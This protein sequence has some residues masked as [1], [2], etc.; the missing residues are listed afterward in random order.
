MTTEAEN[1]ARRQ[2]QELRM[3]AELQAKYGKSAT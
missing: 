3:L 1:L 2:A